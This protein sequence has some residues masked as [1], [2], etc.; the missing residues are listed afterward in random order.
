[1]VDETNMLGKRFTRMEYFY[2]ESPDEVLEADVAIGFVGCDE[3]NSLLDDGIYFYFRDEEE[4][5]ESM[6]G[7][8]VSADFVVVR[9]VI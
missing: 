9:E 2:P 1:M 6:I 7:G 5:A 8:S 4:F 3:C